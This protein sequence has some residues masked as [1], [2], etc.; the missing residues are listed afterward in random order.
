MTATFKRNTWRILGLIFGL[1]A[2]LILALALTSPRSFKLAGAAL[3]MVTLTCDDITAIPKSECEALNALYQ[4]TGGQ[5]WSKS[6][7]WFQAANPCSWYGV[8][9]DEEGEHVSGLYLQINQMTG[10]LPPELA[11]LTHLKDLSLQRNQISGG[12]PVELASLD[13]LETLNLGQN[14]LTDPIPAELGSMARLKVLNLGYNQFSGTIPPQLGNAPD[15]LGLYL[16]NNQLT[17]TLPSEL[18]NLTKLRELYLSNNQLQGEIPPALGN[19]SDL[20]TLHLEANQ[21]SGPIPPQ[22]GS[23]T[24]L[25]K[26]FLQENYLEGIFPPELGNLVNLTTIDLHN[27]AIEGDLPASLTSLSKLG[28]GPADIVDLNFNALYTSDSQTSDFLSSK[29]PNWLMTQTLPPSNLLVANS[30]AGVNLSWSPILYTDDGGY[31]EISFATSPDGPFTVHGH[32]ADKAA[33]SYL[34]DGLSPETQYHFIVRT[35]TPP[36]DSQANELWS[37]YTSLASIT[38]RPL[39]IDLTNFIFLPLIAR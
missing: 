21:L 28:E 38:F 1:A 14:Q 12:L 32:T 2:L 6:Y 25:K 33:S 8:T 19:L 4:A 24:N 36:H 22:M 31:Y 18:G 34:V 9:C 10:S 39:T 16:N 13:R 7:D 20:V 5:N 27:N 15:L 11:Q 26:L 35:Y 3:N 37:D 17:G 23:M 30:Q 29:D